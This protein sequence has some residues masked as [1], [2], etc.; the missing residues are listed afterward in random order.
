MVPGKNL[1]HSFL[2]PS[3][4]RSSPNFPVS[5]YHLWSPSLLWIL[6]ISPGTTQHP[7][8]KTDRVLSLIRMLRWTTSLTRY[9]F[10]RSHK[11]VFCFLVEILANSKCLIIELHWGKLNFHAAKRGLCFLN[12]WTILHLMV[13]LGGRMRNSSTKKRRGGNIVSVSYSMPLE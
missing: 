7:L 11:N 8:Q 1:A 2:C 3:W 9:K 13:L 10:K 12:S 4:C 6:L 5:Q